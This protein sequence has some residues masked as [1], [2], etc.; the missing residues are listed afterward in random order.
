MNPQTNNSYSY[1][2][3]LPA[4]QDNQQDKEIAKKKIIATIIEFGGKACLKQIADKIGLPQSTVSGRISD[5]RED[6]KVKDSGT[7]VKLDGRSRIVWELIQD[8]K[9][10]KNKVV[11][12]S[13]FQ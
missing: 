1:A 11:S 6:R 7:K 2:T 12:T 5:L 9:V 3:S 4:Y 10:D 8:V 13:F